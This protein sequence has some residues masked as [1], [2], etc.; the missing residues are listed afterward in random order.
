MIFW[1]T[2]QAPGEGKTIHWITPPPPPPLP[3]SHSPKC[4]N[5]RKFSSDD[6]RTH[7]NYSTP[8]IM[9]LTHKNLSQIMTSMEG[10]FLCVIDPGIIYLESHRI[11]DE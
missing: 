11:H 9:L 5:R 8:R 3:T 4:P 2:F 10:L 7:E 6:V 1:N